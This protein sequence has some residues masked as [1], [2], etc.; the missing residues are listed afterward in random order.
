MIFMFAPF[1]MIMIGLQFGEVNQNN[2]S[3]LSMMVIPLSKKG[4]VLQWE[5]I[6]GKKSIVLVKQGC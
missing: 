2:T 4:E 6:F 3:E 1:L 5:V